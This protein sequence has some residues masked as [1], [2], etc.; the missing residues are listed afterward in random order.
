MGVPLVHVPVA[1]EA[2]QVDVVDVRGG[3]GCIHGVE[4]GLDG[5]GGA[6]GV[7]VGDGDVWGEA[8]GFVDGAADGADGV[9]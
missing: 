4:S 8:V 9:A 2:D 1:V 6:G 3:R 5:A 7:A